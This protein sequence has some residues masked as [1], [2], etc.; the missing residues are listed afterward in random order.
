MD[1]CSS[2]T[3]WRSSVDLVS[4]SPTSG[5]GPRAGVVASIVISILL[6]VILVA[7]GIGYVY[8]YGRSNPGGWAER[9]A[10]RLESNYKRFGRDSGLGMESLDSSKAKASQGQPDSNLEKVI[11]NNNNSSSS[12]TVSF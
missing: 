6:L 10:L 11:N 12:I 1:M 5:T 2:H 4:A 7:I 9:I 3:E 8:V